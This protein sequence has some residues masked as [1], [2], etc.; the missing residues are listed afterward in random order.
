SYTPKNSAPQA[1][2]IIVGLRSAEI[3][4]I[5]IPADEGALPSG[6]TA[7]DVEQNLRRLQNQG[8]VTFRRP[9]DIA[10][11]TAEIFEVTDT[12]YATEKGFAHGIQVQA[13]KF[14]TA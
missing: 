2:R 5:V 8:T 3:I 10:T 9:G 11:F 4:R 14:V 12:M 7:I 13:R 1:L 6:F